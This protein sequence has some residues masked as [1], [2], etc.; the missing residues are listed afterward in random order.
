MK[1]DSAGMVKQYSI[2]ALHERF[3]KGD[4]NPAQLA[5]DCI[6]QIK[7]HNDSFK[8]F[9]VYDEDICR[10]QAK[11]CEDHLRSGAAVRLLEGIPVGVKDIFNTLEFPTQMGSPLW[12][13]FMP[14]N[15]ARTVFYV[16][17]QG[18]IIPGKTV[19][20]EFAVHTLGDTRNPH[21]ITRTPGTSSSGSAVG[22]ALGMFPVSLGTQTAGS[23]VRP[24]SFCGIYGCKPSFGLIPRTG[25][26]KTTDSLDTIGFFA[27]FHEDLERMFE[28][29]RVKGPDYPVSY[30]ALKDEKRQHKPS[31]RPWK[32][33]LVRTHTWEYAYPYAR[34]AMMRFAQALT[35]I[36]DVDLIETDLPAD[37][38]RAHEI[39]ATIYNK[40]L[41]YY[42]K[43][44]HEKH[45]LVSPIMNGLIEQGKKIT[46]EHYHQALKD[47]ET[48]CHQM[49]AFLEGYDIMISLS[50]AGEAPA[51]DEMEQPDPALMW[52]MT[53]L[54][55][56]SAPLFVSP[57]GLPFGAQIAARRYN[58]YL[59]FRFIR[60]V[61]KQG[62][63]PPGP[64][65]LV[66]CG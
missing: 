49:D 33:A 27:Y 29:L 37:M 19:T 65:P 62:L 11:R 47:Q 8:A 40:T 35:K 28:V 2:G 43:E 9:V 63:L 54:P 32:V 46:V 13:G 31:N 10:E 41:S 38:K 3:R 17:Q 60:H 30:H 56:V 55:V 21:D 25:I 20:A 42:F 7:K 12:K 64:N 48:L 26:L 52:T 5:E 51:R 16:K 4:L 18:G 14:G 61:S 45:E 57:R 53:H 50:T 58:D 22:I 44:E 1:S 23:V 39:H 36:R 24:A 6:R 66:T 15:D 59:L 34:E